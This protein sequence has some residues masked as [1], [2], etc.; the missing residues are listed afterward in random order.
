MAIRVKFGVLFI[1]WLMCGLIAIP[2][3]HAANSRMARLDGATSLF[4]VKIP[5][6]LYIDSIA[7]HKQTREMLVFSNNRLVKIYRVHLGI[8]PVGRKQFSG[9]YRTPEG[10]Y[11]IAYLNAQSLFHLSLGISYPNSSDAAN[12]KKLGKQAGGDIMI[13]GLPN[14]DA[15]A[16]P[17]RYQ[18][19]WT[20]GCI[21][22]RNEEVEE[23][24]M[25]VQPGTSIYIAP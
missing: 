6:G 7:V 13:H 17:E 18:N 22:V 12:A 16:G 24:F 14:A 2:G 1:V 20:W 3:V 19:D 8:N 15:N 9:D 25:H 10:L 4:A 5:E 21:A 11:H 23:L